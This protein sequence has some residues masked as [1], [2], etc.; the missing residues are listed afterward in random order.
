MFEYQFCPYLQKLILSLFMADLEAQ[1]RCSSWI[2][3]VEHVLRRNI[4]HVPKYQEF[5]I[6]KLP[7]FCRQPSAVYA[8]REWRF[9]LHN[10]EKLNTSGSEAI[11]LLIASALGLEGETWKDF[12]K[13]VVSDECL[14]DIKQCYGL[15]E[16]ETILT[17]EMIRYIITLDALFLVVYMESGGLPPEERLV[18]TKGN[19]KEEHLFMLPMAGL[20]IWIFLSID[21]CKIENQVP[22]SLIIDVVES[23]TQTQASGPESCEEITTKGSTES[24]EGYLRKLLRI[25][26]CIGVSQFMNV[27]EEKSFQNPRSL[28]S[29]SSTWKT[30]FLA[31]A[32]EMICG[33]EGLKRR[34]D[35]SFR[36]SYLHIP[37]ATKLRCSGITIEGI[38]GPLELLSYKDGCLFVP[39]MNMFDDTLGVARNLA[40][41]ETTRKGHCIFCDYILLMRDLIQTPM[42]FE[43]LVECGVFQ[44]GVQTAIAVEDWRQVGKGLLMG[45]SSK[46]HH[47]MKEHIVERCQLRRYKLWDAFQLEYCSKP[48]VMISVFTVTLVSVATLIQTYVAVI[49]SDGMKPHFP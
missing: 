8:P 24:Y 41:Y 30:H 14:L 36:G 38:E 9:G 3:K 27:S 13:N 33:D 10:R 5:Y 34:M 44:C 11:K 18:W 39:K 15:R 47:K 7:E 26:A 42:D 4:E 31:T 21:P 32:Y 23:F 1:Q 19:V 6:A 16:E 28:N 17:D 45:N 49:G 40:W 35:L 37:S 29:P 46:E 43:V 25:G 22:F 2:S 12:C 48:W 20:P